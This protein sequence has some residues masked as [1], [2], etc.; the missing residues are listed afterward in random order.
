M[1]NLLEYSGSYS[2]TSGSL[3]NYHKGEMYDDVNEN[4]T[5]NDRINN[6]KTITGKSF[7]YQAK[8]IGST[9]DDDNNTSM[10]YNLLFHQNISD[11]KHLSI[12]L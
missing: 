5:D 6:D 3:R 9:Q 2:V 7:D 11:L 8:I 1:Y 12:C 4:K 10:T